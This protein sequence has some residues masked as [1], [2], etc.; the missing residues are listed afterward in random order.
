MATNT[1]IRKSNFTAH[2][3]FMNDSDIFKIT[4]YLLGMK[5]DDLEAL[6]NTI[7]LKLTKQNGYVVDY[8]PILIAVSGCYSSTLL[9]K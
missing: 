9:S 7:N 5:L 3:S 2:W 8:N 1:N 6:Y 4:R